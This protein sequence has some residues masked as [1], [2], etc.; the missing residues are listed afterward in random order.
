MARTATEIQADIDIFRE[1]IRNIALTG[2][3]YEIGSGPSKRVFE[4]A[5][6][7]KLRD[8]LASLENELANVNGTSGVLVG[9]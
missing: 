7:D 3:K 4:A 6:L 2:Q 5:D 1:A 8:Y 9:F